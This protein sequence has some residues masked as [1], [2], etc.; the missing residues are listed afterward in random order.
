MKFKPFKSYIIFE[1]DNLIAINKPSMVSSLQDRLGI[2]P[3]V[4]DW[5]KSYFE[6][7]QLC[8]RLDKET[9]GIMLIAKNPETYREM[10]IKFEKREVDKTYWAIADGRHYFEQLTV[11][12]PLAVSSKGRAKVDKQDGKPAETDF[13]VVETFKHFSLIE[14]KPITGRLHQIRIHLAT[15]NAQ[16]AGDRVYGGSSPFLSTIKRNYNYPKDE[17]PRPMIQRA[18]LHAKRISFSLYGNSFNIDAPLS[19][20]MN[21]FLKL[22]RKYDSE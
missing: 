13:T 14:C 9:S 5:A 16:I 6:N 15:Q 17:E 18:A 1:D 7:C 10:A 12:I 21:V 22:I 11:D 8:H 20:D 2:Q 3:S 19:K 4:H